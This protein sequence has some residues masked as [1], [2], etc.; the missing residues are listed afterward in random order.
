MISSDKSRF[1]LSA[2]ATAV[3]RGEITRSK[4]FSLAR[5]GKYSLSPR[6][7][8]SSAR[9][10]FAEFERQSLKH[11]LYTSNIRVIRPTCRV[12]IHCEPP[13]WRFVSHIQPKIISGHRGTTSAFLRKYQV[14]KLASAHRP[15]PRPRTRGKRVRHVARL[16][17]AKQI[18]AGV[19]FGL[20]T[21]EYRA[22]A[23]T[24]ARF[25]S[26][27]R[28]HRF[29]AR[30]SSHWVNILGDVSRGLFKRFGSSDTSHASASEFVGNYWGF[31][32]LSQA[33]RFSDTGLLVLK[34]CQRQ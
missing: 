26:P 13:Q 20:Q 6:F 31:L 27:R 28:G 2:S 12:D 25:K 23:T 7:A 3:S 18:Y 32:D 22:A 9:R 21:Q 5:A 33:G 24:S 10:V 19:A 8:L 30:A 1:V 4:Y 17:L 34:K 15:N 16:S 11:R 29:G 14:Q